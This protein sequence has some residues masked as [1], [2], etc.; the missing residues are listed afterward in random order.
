M[1]DIAEIEIKVAVD[2]LTSVQQQLVSQWIIFWV[3]KTQHD[4]VYIAQERNFPMLQVWDNALRIRTMIQNDITSHIFTLKHQTW[5]DLAKIE[6]ETIIKNPQHMHEAILL[7]GYKEAS[8]TEKTRTTAIYKN[9]EICLDS[10]VW[11]WDFIEVEIQ[12]HDQA[13]EQLQQEMIDFLTS[14][15][16][17]TS[18]RVTKWYDVLLREKQI[19]QKNQ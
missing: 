4:R 8:Y 2:D 17:D 15:W 3:L 11:L 6:K 14:L 13:Y 1:P 7:M 12:S 10:V 19:S 18:K 5:N 9:M 16:I